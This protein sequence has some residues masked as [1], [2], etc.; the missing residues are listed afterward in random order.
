MEE[1]QRS[2]HAAAEPTDQTVLCFNTTVLPVDWVAAAG[3]HGSVLGALHA[4]HVLFVADVRQERHALHQQ[5][6]HEQ[7]QTSAGCGFEH[8]RST[9]QHGT[10]E[11][12]NGMGMADLANYPHNWQRSWFILLRKIRSFKTWRYPAL[13]Q[14][15]QVCPQVHLPNTQ[16]RQWSSTLGVHEIVLLLGVSMVL[17][18]SQECHP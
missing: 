14:D 12:F 8:H 4:G 6:Q 1:Q 18:V 15:R 10:A 17:Q 16:T 11:I 13:R 7:Q 9:E 5:Q 2:E 3:L